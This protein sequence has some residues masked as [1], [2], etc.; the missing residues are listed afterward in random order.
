[1]SQECP[2]CGK[3]M[4]ETGAPIWEIWCETPECVERGRKEMFSLLRQMIEKDGRALLA[5]LKKKYE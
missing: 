1:M 3:I 5:E 2:H 4:L